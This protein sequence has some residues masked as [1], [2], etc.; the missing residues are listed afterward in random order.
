MY[1]WWWRGKNGL[2]TTMFQARI[3][4][5]LLTNWSTWY[6]LSFLIFLEKATGSIVKLIMGGVLL[7]NMKSFKSYISMSW[8]ITCL[9]SIT[10]FMHCHYWKSRVWITVTFMNQIIKQIIIYQ[11]IAVRI[12]YQLPS[13][14]DTI[15]ACVHIYWTASTNNQVI[16]SVLFFIFFSFLFSPFCSSVISILLS[17]IPVS[18][19]RL[20]WNAVSGQYN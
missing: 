9:P 6:H 1:I 13:Q 3:R 19:V 12:G 14:P 16:P 15:K 10:I 5:C 18:Q 2:A 4:F 8:R 17:P 20:L 11:E 7:C